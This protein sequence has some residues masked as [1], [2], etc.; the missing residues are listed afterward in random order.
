[1]TATLGR[2]AGRGTAVATVLHL[3]AVSRVHGK[4]AGRVH[5]LRDVDLSVRAG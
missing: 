1:V 5:A 4:G 3:E 2:P